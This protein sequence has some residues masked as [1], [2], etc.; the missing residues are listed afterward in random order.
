[1]IVG[2][3]GYGKAGEAERTKS[4]A[5]VALVV[6]L[7]IVSRSDAWIWKAKITTW[8]MRSLMVI[9]VP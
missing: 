9:S 6:E 8:Y 3:A 2:L 1:M 5:V 4:A 7:E